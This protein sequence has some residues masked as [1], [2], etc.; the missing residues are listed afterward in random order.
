M[1]L[2]SNQSDLFRLFRRKARE[3]WRDAK[4]ED[5]EAA[6]EKVIF[7]HFGY[8]PEPRKERQ[9]ATKKKGRLPR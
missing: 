2:Q 4:P 6:L 1:A 5:I 8:P 7:D 3:V 9:R